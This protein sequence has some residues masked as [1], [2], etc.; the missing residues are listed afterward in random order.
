MLRYLP[1]C[2]ALVLLATGSVNAQQSETVFQKID[3]PN[4]GFNIVLAL[5]K[6]GGRA[7]PLRRLRNRPRQGPGSLLHRPHRYS[8]A[9]KL[10]RRPG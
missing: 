9:A 3:V 8:A 4:A 7:D 10:R 5:P 6:A 2:T 1:I